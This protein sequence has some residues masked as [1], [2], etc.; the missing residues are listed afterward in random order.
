LVSANR[1]GVPKDFE[2]SEAERAVREKKT[3]KYARLKEEV[4]AMVNAGAA[5][6]FV[7]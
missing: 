6:V 7:E 1:H 2:L 4:L 3:Q 5:A